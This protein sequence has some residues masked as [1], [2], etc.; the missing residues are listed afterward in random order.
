VA[1]EARARSRAARRE[2]APAGTAE[3]RR[4]RL[5]RGGRVNVGNSST[6]RAA[7]ATGPRYPAIPNSR[8]ASFSDVLRSVD[9]L[10]SPITSAHGVP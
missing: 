4:A 8:N 9:G 3:V 7:P 2:C 10:R 1:R 5:T 6:A